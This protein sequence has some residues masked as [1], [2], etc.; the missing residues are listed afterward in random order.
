MHNIMGSSDAGGG[1][2]ASPQPFAPEPAWKRYV[3]GSRDDGSQWKPRQAE[4]H[5]APWTGLYRRN[6]SVIGSDPNSIKPGQELDLGGGQSHTVKAGETLSGIQS[7]Y[8]GGS[9]TPTPPSRP[10]GLG[11]SYGQGQEPGAAASRNVEQM[12]KSQTESTKPG[13]ANAPT[14]PERPSGTGGQAEQN[15]GGGGDVPTPPVKPASL[16]GTGESPSGTISPLASEGGSG[17]TTLEPSDYQAS[18][19]RMRL[20]SSGTSQSDSAKP[21]GR[22]K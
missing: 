20:M 4:V 22:R 17:G 1:D 15:A 10:A 19:N 14:P 2:Y 8:G 21:R 9:D 11:E 3:S 7:Q 5:D 13:A 16:G 12:L 18:A 6:A